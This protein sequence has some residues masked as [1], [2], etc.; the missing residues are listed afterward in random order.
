[1]F[2]K[3]VLAVALVLG[4]GSMAYATDCAVQQQRVVQFQTVPAFQ[5]VVQF[6]EVPHVQF[7]QGHAFVQQP[8]VVQQLNVAKVKQA[9]NRNLLRGRARVSKNVTVQRSVQR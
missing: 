1:M 8:V 7:V 3:V 5:P 6:V 9:N 4:L 2:K